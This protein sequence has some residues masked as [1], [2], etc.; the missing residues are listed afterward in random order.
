MSDF[1][2]YLEA[3]ILN[4]VR[5]Q[6]FPAAPGTVY[7]AL[8]TTATSDA[9]AITEP[10]ATGYARVAATFGVP[11]DNAGVQEIANS[12]EV[13]FGPA[14]GGNWGTLTHFAVF[15]ALTGGNMLYHNA[16][17]ASVTVNDGES[18]KFDP[19]DLV[20]GAA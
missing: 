16:L 4:F 15:D 12:A 14:S 7:A 11:A 20:L 8:S 9:G 10:V 5:G 3:A 17:T 18:A 6:T 2:D 13:L 1:S 19:G